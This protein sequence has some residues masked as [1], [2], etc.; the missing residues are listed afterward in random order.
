MK[1][2]RKEMI[3]ALTECIVAVYPHNK[4]EDIRVSLE[5][6]EDQ[7]LQLLV[8]ENLDLATDRRIMGITQINV[9]TQFILQLILAR[10]GYIKFKGEK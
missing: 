6:K 4:P 9:F 5:E 8:H 7:E 3:N 2:N 10:Y 1:T